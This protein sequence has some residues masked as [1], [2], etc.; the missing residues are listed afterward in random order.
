M[1]FCISTAVKAQFSSSERVYYYYYVKTVNDGVTSKL[2]KPELY[3]VNF[4]NEFL[5]QKFS[6]NHVL[7]MIGNSMGGFVA[8]T[9]AI[10]FQDYADFIICG[11][12]S[13]KVAGHD[14][15]LSHF[16]NEIIES[17]FDIVKTKENI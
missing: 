8:L 10:N 4:Q 2:S 17:D 5:A 3:V 9:S 11:V 15:I 6:I 16:V 7:G 13:Y 12:S 1:F 14:F